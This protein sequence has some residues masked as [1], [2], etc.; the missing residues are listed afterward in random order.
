MSTLQRIALVFTVIGA[1]NWGLIGFFQ[2]DL[3]AAIFGGQNSALAR[4]IYGIVGISGLINLSLLFKPSENLGT[5]PE[6]HE[7]R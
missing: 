5:H 2:F 1:V 3:V 7:I 6:T 4:I